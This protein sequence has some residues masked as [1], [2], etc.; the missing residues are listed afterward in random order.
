MIP[1]SK[2]KPVV[3]YPNGTTIL[4]ITEQR[5]IINN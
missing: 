4:N 3:I 1:L 5:S 2:T